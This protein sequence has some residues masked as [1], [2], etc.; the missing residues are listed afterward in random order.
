MYHQPIPLNERLRTTGDEI[1]RLNNELCDLSIFRVFRRKT[2]L[3]RLRF[4]YKLQEAN[5]IELKNENSI[6]ET[7]WRAASEFEC[8]KAIMKALREEYVFY[9]TMGESGTSYTAGKLAGIQICMFAVREVCE[10]G[11]SEDYEQEKR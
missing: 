1:H 6:P 2:L 8:C 4:A 5:L 9:S 7:G 3:K 11:D 10:Y